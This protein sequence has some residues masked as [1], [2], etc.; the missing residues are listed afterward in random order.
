MAEW[1]ASRDSKGRPLQTVLISKLWLC[2]VRAV[3]EKANP[4]EGTNEA[5]IDD[6]NPENITVSSFFL[7]PCVAKNERDVRRHLLFYVE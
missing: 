3:T 2:G 6:S 1:R 7:F 4:P 5:E